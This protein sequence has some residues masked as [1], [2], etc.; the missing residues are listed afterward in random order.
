MDKIGELTT[1]AT[2]RKRGA[3]AS[4][5]AREEKQKPDQTAEIT[6]EYQH[7]LEQ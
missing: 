7:Q 2:V 5:E 1:T 6:K 3:E 4:Q